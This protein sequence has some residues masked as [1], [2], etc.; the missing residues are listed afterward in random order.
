MY[1]HQFPQMQPRM[2]YPLMLPNPVVVVDM[3]RTMH[4]L[5]SCFETPLLDYL[6]KTVCSVDHD[7]WMMTTFLDLWMLLVL[8]LM[9]ARMH[10]DRPFL[11]FR[12]RLVPLQKMD[13]VPLTF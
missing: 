9:V 5:S 8:K 12:N 3:Q 2:D 10:R 6:T 1:S 11:A 13:S 4:L 7:C